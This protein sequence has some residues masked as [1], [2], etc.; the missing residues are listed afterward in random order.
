M[1][2]HLWLERSNC[3]AWERFRSGR[4][5]TNVVAGIVLS[6][7]AL[8]RP[9]LEINCTA[10]SQRKL[11]V[12]TSGPITGR[13]EVIVAIDG[14]AKRVAH[15]ARKI[16]HIRPTARTKQNSPP[17]IDGQLELAFSGAVAE[18]ARKPGAVAIVEA[19]NFPLSP[20]QNG[21]GATVNESGNKTKVARPEPKTNGRRAENG[22]AN[23]VLIL[24][25]R[26][27]GFM[28]PP[29]PVTLADDENT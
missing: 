23:H 11:N 26:L 7:T 29:I 24:H 19:A 6:A 3:S 12:R 22:V 9:K 1:L 28:K 10:M 18:S 15:L 8:W 27:G 5:A 20:E 13:N 14:L 21:G 25:D 16:E 2:A 4:I 17:K